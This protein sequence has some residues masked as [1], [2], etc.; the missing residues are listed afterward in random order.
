[1]L[2]KRI[3]ASLHNIT[4]HCQSMFYGKLFTAHFER[5]SWS[6]VIGAPKN[7][8]YLKKRVPSNFRMNF[9]RHI[10]G[11][12]FRNL[13]ITNIYE[14]HLVAIV[15]FGHWPDNHYCTNS[16]SS[17]HFSSHHCTFCA[18]LHVKTSP[19]RTYWKTKNAWLLCL[20]GQTGA[21]SGPLHQGPWKASYAPGGNPSG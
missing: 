19:D 16:L 21:H 2:C 17:L 18:S 3:L 14:F 1:M 5:G 10:R 13:N 4:S 6:L 8:I 7:S 20:K 15:Y 11:Q 9:T 12:L